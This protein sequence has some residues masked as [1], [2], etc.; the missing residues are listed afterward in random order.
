MAN[1]FV[2]KKGLI[3]TGNS[4][5]TGSLGVT[6][7][8]TASAFKGD[9]SQLTNIVSAYATTASYAATASYVIGAPP[10]SSWASASISSSYAERARYILDAGIIYGNI[11][12][13]L[14]YSD[15]VTTNYV[16]S[17]SYGDTELLVYVDGLLN[18]NIIDYTFVPPTNTLA[19]TSYI[20]SE[21]IIS[22]K[23]IHAIT[24]SQALTIGSYT[25]YA[26]GVT[27]EYI[28]SQSYN[29]ISLFVYIDGILNINP[30]N[31]TFDSPLRKLTFSA[32]PPSGS[33]IAIKTFINFV[34][35]SAGTMTGSL[36][37]TA[38]FAETASNALAIAYE[39]IYNKPTLVSSS[40]QFNNL[41]SPFTGSFTGSFT[42]DGSNLIGTVSASYAVSSSY[43]PSP[44][45]KS[46]LIPYTSF[47]GNPK[48]ST[49]TFAT[50]F[51]DNN[52]AV[53]VTGEDAR[54]WTIQ[55]KVS[56]S[57]VINSNS[58]VDLTGNTYWIA[59]AVGEI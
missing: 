35:S 7:D 8:V 45:T 57:F 38:S 14:F 58:I 43:A 49:V 2:A 5:I 21:S 40:I 4:K 19:F 52:Y 54:T 50:P 10:S 47:S 41:S 36:L 18:E 53:T 22:V 23:G 55:S 42:G 20:P 48:I 51:T 59:V 9:G 30:D 13:Y 28:L 15:G 17:S 27:S 31:Y 29:D 24:S 39:N 3:V 25:F 56:G 12:S 16:L 46:G 26:D 11:D 6:A 32:Y 1:E 44:R 34:S 33:T 37:G